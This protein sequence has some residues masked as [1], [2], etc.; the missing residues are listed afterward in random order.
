MKLATF[1]A[2]VI[3]TMAFILVWLHPAIIQ[4]KESGSA[5]VLATSLNVRSGPDLKSSVVG[6]LKQDAIVSVSGESFGWVKIKSGRTVGWVA[7]QY[8]KRLTGAEADKPSQTVKSAAST[9]GTKRASVLV[10]SLHMREEPGTGSSIL[11]VL[12]LGTSLK[13]LDRKQD[14]IHAQTAE[15]D[16]GWVFGKYIG[17]P[18]EEPSKPAGEPAKSTESGAKGIKGKIIVVDPGHGGNDPGVIGKKYG[19]VEK[20]INLTTARYL[21]DKLREAGAQVVMTRNKDDDKPE[22]SERSDLSGSKRADA[23]ISIH[24]NSSPKPISGTLTFFYSKNKDMPLAQKIEA[25]LDRALGLKSNG[26]SFGDYHVLREN[27]RPSVLIEL[28]FLSNPKDEAIVR[29]ADYQLQAAE[30]IV[31][32]LKDYFGG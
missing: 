14:W 21:A 24:Y 20:S 26:I 29:G 16:K 10:D 6:S 4:A 15:G 28:G 32:G 25:R 1:K 8:L 31:S 3:S 23:F 17:E 13:I 27:R 22:L 9:A 2:A 12:E 30:A 7:G 19:T 5:R 11:R 18:A